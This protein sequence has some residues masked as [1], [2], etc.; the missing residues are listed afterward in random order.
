M[1]ILETRVK[2]NVTEMLNMLV[3]FSKDVSCQRSLNYVILSAKLV[4]N[5]TGQPCV[6]YCMST[7]KDL[8]ELVMGVWEAYKASPDFQFSVEEVRKHRPSTMYHHSVI[9]GERP[10]CYR[11]ATFVDTSQIKYWL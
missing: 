10:E 3:D 11:F 7:I 5:S 9:T 8:K 4:E 6:L 1:E 2:K